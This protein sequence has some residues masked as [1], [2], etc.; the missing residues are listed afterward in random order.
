[1]VEFVKVATQGTC[2]VTTEEKNFAENGDVSKHF[3][4]RFSVS[5]GEPAYNFMCLISPESKQI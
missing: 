5:F 4:C 3:S 1:M 2:D